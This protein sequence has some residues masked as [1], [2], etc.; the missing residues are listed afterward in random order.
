MSKF[1]KRLFEIPEYG[2][3]ESN[4]VAKLTNSAAL[5]MLLLGVIFVLA[6]AFTAPELVKRAAILAATFGVPHLASLHLSVITITACQHPASQCHVA[7]TPSARYGWWSFRAYLHWLSVVI[8]A[9]IDLVRM[10]GI[11]IPLICIITGILTTEINGL[12]PRPINTPQP[13]GWNLWILL[14]SHSCCKRQHPKQVFQGGK[15]NTI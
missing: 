11:S 5:G 6:A 1:T 15:S 3:A 4:V 10:V 8:L 9:R 2:D 12:L 14:P 7:S 13:P